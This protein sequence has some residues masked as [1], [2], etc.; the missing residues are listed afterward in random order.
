MLEPLIVGNKKDEMVKWSCIS[1]LMCRLILDTMITSFINH[2][3]ELAV[4]C[5]EKELGVGRAY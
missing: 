2:G 4:H 1:K 5:S 3:D